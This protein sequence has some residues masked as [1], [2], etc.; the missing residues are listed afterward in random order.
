MDSNTIQLI[1]VA[2]IILAALT[3]S[4][5]SI[6]RLIKRKDKHASPCCGCALSK[7]CTKVG[8]PTDSNTCTTHPNP[9][10]QQ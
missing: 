9:T 4:V 7:S 3:W 5:V 6:I 1:I 2:I 8:T 10:D